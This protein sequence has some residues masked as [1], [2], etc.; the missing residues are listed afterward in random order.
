MLYAFVDAE[1]NR[2]A[3]TCGATLDTSKGSPCLNG[4]RSCPHGCSQHA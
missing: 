3:T 4:V 2:R 1:P